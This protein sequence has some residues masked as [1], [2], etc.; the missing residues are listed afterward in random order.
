[1]LIINVKFRVWNLK[2]DSKKALSTSERIVPLFCAM[3]WLELKFRNLPEKVGLRYQSKPNPFSLIDIVTSRKLISSL[4]LESRNFRFTRKRVNFLDV[5]ISING[6][7]F[8]FDWYRKPTFSGRF[9]NFNSN[10]PMAQ[11]RGT[12]LSLTELFCYRTLDFIHRIWR[13]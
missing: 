5:T 3:G 11:K 13:S 7:R 2:S 6:N 10:H 4:N 9:L 12:I 8:G 1:M